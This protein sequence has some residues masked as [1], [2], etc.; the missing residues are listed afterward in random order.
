MTRCSCPTAR[1]R[2]SDTLYSAAGNSVD[3]Q[4]YN[5]G[6]IAYLFE[7]G[8]QRIVGEPDTG[9]IQRRDVGFQPCFGGPGTS[10]S[11]GTACGTVDNPTR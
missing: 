7:A 5:H 10:G 8:A 2:S 3:E 6:I 9:A 4:W 11:M 1:A